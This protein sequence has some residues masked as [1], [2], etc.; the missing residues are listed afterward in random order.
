MCNHDLCSLVFPSAHNRQIKSQI[1]RQYA[2]RGEHRALGIVRPM[3][4]NCGHTP[5]IS[6]HNLKF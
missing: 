5:R 4:T 1:V 2:V 6:R 3:N